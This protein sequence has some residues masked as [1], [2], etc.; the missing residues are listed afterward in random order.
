MTLTFEITQRLLKR[1]T[2]DLTYASWYG[3][4]GY[5]DPK[6]LILF[7]NWN[8]VPLYLQHGLERRG[9]AIEWYD[10]WIIDYDT[11][12]AYRTSPDCMS[13]T[14]SYYMNESGEIYGKAE[15]SAEDRI[16]YFMNNSD[17]LEPFDLDFVPYGWYEFNCENTKPFKDLDNRYKLML[18]MNDHGLDVAFQDCSDGTVRIW[19]KPQA[20]E[21]THESV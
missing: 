4:P 20:D 16:R 17:E 1:Y 14:P 10:E 3:E 9:Y 11:D 21:K 6:N 19:L 18:H 13:W 8:S 2:D 7:T 5:T 15:W 12:K